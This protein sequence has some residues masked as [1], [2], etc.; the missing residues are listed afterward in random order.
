M[1]VVEIMEDGR[2]WP[3]TLMIE[4]S[5]ML[6]KMML[7]N[8]GQESSSQCNSRVN[9]CPHELVGIGLFV[10]LFIIGA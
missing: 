8:R 2:E 1:A 10:M 7:C 5:T 6:G 4:V 3:T 9:C